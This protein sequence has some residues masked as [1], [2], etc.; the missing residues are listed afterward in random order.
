MA[1]FA[2][3]LTV[4]ALAASVAIISPAKA[5]PT[6]EYSL[7]GGAFSTFGTVVGGNVIFSGNIGSFR[8]NLL[9][10]T[11]NTPGTPTLAEL[12]SSSLAIANIG[13][14]TQ[15]IEFLIGDNGFTKPSAPPSL[16][17][18]SH[19]G[20]SVVVGGPGNSLSFASCVDPSNTLNGCGAG[21]TI[22]G[23]G[24][25]NIANTGSFQDD[26]TAIV[27]ILGVPYSMRQDIKITLD[28][29]KSFN[30]SDNTTLV[31]VPEP[32]SLV[33]L[34]MGLLGMGMFARTRRA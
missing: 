18:N 16:L 13:T 29:G 3:L 10:A 31:S 7:N 19:I 27:S 15:S 11:S 26:K 8:I 1:K 20:G 34:G 17:L 30:F 4:A 21:S 9:A 22:A 2:R 5:V 33:L 24:T 32:A 28:A 12:L 23:P 25:P 6:L 14:I